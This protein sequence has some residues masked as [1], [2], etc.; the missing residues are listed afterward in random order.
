V[1][2]LCLVWLWKWWMEPTR[3]ETTRI[4]VMKLTSKCGLHQLKRG[5]VR[6]SDHRRSNTIYLLKGS[7]PPPSPNNIIEWDTYLDIWKYATFPQLQSGQ[8][9]GMQRTC[10]IEYS[11]WR[12]GNA[13]EQVAKFPFQP[14][15]DFWQVASTACSS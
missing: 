7:N 9:S 3:R 8:T 4:Q 2:A 15:K 13:F 10:F 1:A 14:C 6:I 5:Y 12:R 11:Q